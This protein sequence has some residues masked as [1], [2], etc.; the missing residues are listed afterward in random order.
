[1]P[2]GAAALAHRANNRE[3]ANGTSN[4]QKS[5]EDHRKPESD[6]HKPRQDSKE[7]E[8]DREKSKEDPQESG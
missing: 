1:L 8:D 4:S 5:K 3:A 7:P 6:R 2:V